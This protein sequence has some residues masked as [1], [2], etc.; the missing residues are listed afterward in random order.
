VT[1]IQGKKKYYAREKV[2]SL[3]IYSSFPRDQ[4]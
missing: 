1:M 2:V 4:H 3:K